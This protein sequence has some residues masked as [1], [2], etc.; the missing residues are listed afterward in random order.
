MYSQSLT[1]IC[2]WFCFIATILLAWGCFEGAPHSNPLDP[3]SDN[4]EDIGAIT[5]S[6]TGFYPPFQG[7]EAVEIRLSPGGFL[8]TTDA[9]GRFDFFNLEPGQY[10]VSAER[11]GFSTVADTIDV[12]L[13]QQN[14]DHL[15]N[16][17]L[18]SYYLG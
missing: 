16:E 14:C 1:Q 4:F 13:N 17:W 8:T 3:R 7:L 5:G 9:S 6:V 10:I 15:P 18:A 12:V 11:S 2:N